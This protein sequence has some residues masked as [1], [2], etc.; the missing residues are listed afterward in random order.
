[1]DIPSRIRETMRRHGY[2]AAALAIVGATALFIPFRELLGGE[3]W[4]WPYLLVLGFVA[5]T[6]GVG[7][8]VLSAVLAFFAWNFFFIPPYHTLFV[9]SRGDVIH[10]AAFL[11]VGTAIGLQTGR[12][13]DRELVAQREER[14]TAALNRLS[15][16]L[17]SETNAASLAEAA[18][19]E[20]TDIAHARAAAFWIP[21]ADGA[22][23]SIGED[24]PPASEVTRLWRHMTSGA[25]TTPGPVV[26]TPHGEG[27]EIDGQRML[28]PL[29]SAQTAE[30]L[31][32]L[33]AERPLD[34]AESRFVRSLANL[35][36]AFLHSQRL[37]RVAMH[38]AAAQEAERLRSAVVSSVSHELK[39][40]LASITAAVTDLLEP[41]V[42]RDAGAIREK[43]HDI[44][45]DLDRLDEA[46]ADL[47]D[48]SRLEAQAWRPRPDDFEVGELVGSVVSRL[49]RAARERIR[50]AVPEDLPMLHLD[51][52]QLSRA[53][54]HV[55]VNAIDYSEGPVTVGAAADDRMTV[56]VS[57]T[58]PG[59]PADEKPLVFDK[60]YRGREGRAHRSS[61]GL[62]LS[63]TREI[64]R[65]N[66]GDIAIA[67][68]RPR[69]TRILLMLPLKETP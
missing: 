58:G 43:L 2:P 11:V 35:L 57:D 20:L 16:S 4:G 39:T 55:I 37:N 51:F 6:A 7:P 40:P 30:G 60:F 49:P 59:I 68:E 13:R 53:L 18:R 10:L 56:W 44:T 66:E 24:A 34:E 25:D 32:E 33:S 17:V 23:R 3:R 15:R 26:V 8:G 31:L 29:V 1:M 36:A 19:R 5:G 69:G 38:A 45:E 21:G 65:A 62:G 67:D 42:E 22:L 48:V 54:H 50:F 52:V 28:V 46:I 61:T 63:I 9:A 64:L 41:D 27:E 12:L 47:L 14:H